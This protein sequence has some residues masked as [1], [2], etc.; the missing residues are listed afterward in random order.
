MLFRSL[1]AEG[2]DID[3]GEMAFGDVV[4][5]TR[6]SAWQICGLVCCALLLLT[7]GFVMFDLL[8]TLGSSRDLTL[9]GPLLN[10]LAGVFGWRQ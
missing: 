5:D 2:P 6:F 9:S 7:G 8:R 10:P 3:G 4:P 1:N